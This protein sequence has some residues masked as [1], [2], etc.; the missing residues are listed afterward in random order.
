MELIQ[1]VEYCLFHITYEERRRIY[2][3]INSIWSLRGNMVMTN[4]KYGFVNLERMPIEEEELSFCKVCTKSKPS[5]KIRKT[6][7]AG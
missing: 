2:V 5:C 3:I 4:T 6:E 7:S 1:W